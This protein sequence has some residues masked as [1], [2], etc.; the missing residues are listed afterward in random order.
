MEQ[1]RSR[2]ISALVPPKEEEV[3]HFGSGYDLQ[4]RIIKMAMIVICLIGCGYQVFTIMAI[5]F[6]FP[7]NVVVRVETGKLDLPGITICSSVK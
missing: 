3:S 7:N 6:L 5:F 2:R 4:W 1:V